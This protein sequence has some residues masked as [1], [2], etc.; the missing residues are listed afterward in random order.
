MGLGLGLEP[1]GVLVHASGLLLCATKGGVG[2]GVWGGIA[3]WVLAL[4]RVRLRGFGFGFGFG[5]IY[6]YI[7]RM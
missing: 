2:Q 5:Y 7:Y 3:Y 1:G 6:K 4:P